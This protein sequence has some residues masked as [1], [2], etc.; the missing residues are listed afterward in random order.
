MENK[1]ITSKSLWVFAFILSLG[2]VISAAV[3]GYALK[4]S[5]RSQ[6][7]ISVKGL[8]EKP[9]KA[10]SARWEINVQ[11]P[12]ASNSIPEAYQLL[13]QNLK[14]L[15]AFFVEQGFKATDLIFS[16]FSYFNQPIL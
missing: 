15:Q 6:N 7:S 5:N 4:Q 11:T 14:T 1:T 3:I 16:V 2:F 10:D 12:T 13:D 8:S 9:I